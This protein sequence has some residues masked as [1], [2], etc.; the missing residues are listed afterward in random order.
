MFLR[1]TL[2]QAFDAAFVPA[3]V[4]L[5]AL[6]SFGLGRLSALDV[7][8]KKVVIHPADNLTAIAPPTPAS[9]A[10]LA[11]RAPSAPDADTPHNFVASKNGAKYYPAGCSG[12]NR[13]S[14]A[15]RVWFATA[16]AAEAVGYA[17]ASGC[18]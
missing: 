12:A 13:I 16:A 15:N 18:K 3:V 9:S 8:K 7:D 11:P 10:F 2:S 17:L 5:V 14:D 4:V 1:K 6:G